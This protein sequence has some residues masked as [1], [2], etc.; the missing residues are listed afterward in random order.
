MYRC[1][2]RRGARGISP[3]W[4]RSRS[5]RESARRAAAA[6]AERVA[7]REFSFTLRLARQQHLARDLERGVLE[8]AAADRAVRLG[9][10]YPHARA[11]LARRRAARL[12]HADFNERGHAGP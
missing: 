1:R 3:P 2:A 11:R 12:E 7:E 6:L 4:S 9:R 5:G 10:A 8:V